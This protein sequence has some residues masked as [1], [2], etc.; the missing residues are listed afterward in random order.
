MVA[1]AVRT[2]FAQPDA[3]SVRSQLDTIAGMLSR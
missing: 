2:T 1:A 3:A